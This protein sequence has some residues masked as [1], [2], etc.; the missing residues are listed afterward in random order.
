M[1]N[2]TV[3]PETLAAALAL[4][5]LFAGDSVGMAPDALEVP[6]VGTSL[7]SLGGTFA[8][9][10]YASGELILAEK[11]ILQQSQAIVSAENEI[12]QP[13]FDTFFDSVR[14]LSDLELQELV[15]ERST[16][17]NTSTWSLT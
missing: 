2:I 4:M 9:R 13:A 16:F 15:K 14:S 17:R 3:D 11:P 6:G 1:D 5:D 7:L 8:D 12:L 10:D